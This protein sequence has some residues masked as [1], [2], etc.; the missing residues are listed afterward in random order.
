MTDLSPL[1]D[2]IDVSVWQQK[3]YSPHAPEQAAFD[4]MVGLGTKIAVMLR[5]AAPGSV[6]LIEGYV[7]W[8][9]PTFKGNEPMIAPVGFGARTPTLDDFPM[10]PSDTEG[11]SESDLNQISEGMEKWLV[12]PVFEKVDQTDLDKVSLATAQ[13]W[14][15]YALEREAEK[16]LR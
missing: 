13:Q 14:Q 12:N 7:Y 16:R 2:A 9:S 8:V 6:A 10:S 4:R 1:P 11:Q 15:R 5:N 3:F